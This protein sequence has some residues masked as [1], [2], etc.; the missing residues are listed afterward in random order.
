MRWPDCFDR[1][2]LERLSL[3]KTRSIAA[4]AGAA[5]I[6]AAAVPDPARL[7]A[8]LAIAGRS[9]GPLVQAVRKAGRAVRP[10]KRVAETGKPNAVIWDEAADRAIGR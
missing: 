5:E 6:I 2:H 7:C 1:A 8:L 10:V 9:Y 4:L 3:R